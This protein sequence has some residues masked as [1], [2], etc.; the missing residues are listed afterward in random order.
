[1]DSIFFR[2]LSSAALFIMMAGVLV[3]NFSNLTGKFYFSHI[4]NFQTGVKTPGRTLEKIRLISDYA[5]KFDPLCADYHYAGAN[6]SL[7]L[8]QEKS[9]L[10]D[11]AKAIYLNPLNSIFLKRA[12]LYM[13]KKGETD[14]ATKLLKASVD[15]DISDAENALQYGAWLISQNRAGQ[16]IQM[17][18]QAVSLDTKLMDRALT[19]MAVLN[20]DYDKMQNA[21]PQIPGPALAYADFLY[22][23]G[24]RKEAET[25]YLAALDYIEKEEKISR[26]QYYRIYRFFLKRGKT[27]KA[28][29]V[30][31]RAAAVLP[32]DPEIRI[33]MGDIY[34][35][36]GVTYRAEQ[37][38]EQALF[39]DSKNTK[40][41]NRL[42]QIRGRS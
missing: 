27:K 24:K 9:V 12:G 10:K 25:N 8:K 23:S 32:F 37:E 26:W 38:Y 35:K 34:K 1:V 18:K 15:C 6:A 21:V 40:A 39:I 11:L 22:N 30:M 5:S 17:I 31:Q 13:I 16:G 7:F 4:K 42:K 33:I 20:V 3:F 36:M 41:K 2:R 28:L 29:K 19:N 14:S